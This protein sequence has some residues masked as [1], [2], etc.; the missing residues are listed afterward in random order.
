MEHLDEMTCLLYLEGQFDAQRARACSDHVDACPSCRALLRTLE[1]ESLLFVRAL[2]EEEE[3]VPARLLAL[4]GRG[5]RPLAWAWAASLA[6]AATGSYALYA[7]YVQ[8]AQ[9]KLAQ[10][11][12]GAGS[13]FD[14]LLFEVAFWK[15][16][17]PMLTLLETLAFLA[18]CGVA[19]ALLSP[20]LRRWA[21]FAAVLVLCLAFGGLP[22]PTSAAEVRHAQFEVVPTDQT[23]KND[24]IFFGQSLRI[25]GAVDGDVIAFGNSVDVNGRVTGDL[26]SF[27]QSVH[28]T[29]EIDG[30]IRSFS[31][32]LTLSGRVGKNV[33]AFLEKW[34]LEPEGK[35]GGSLTIFA[36]TLSLDGK[37]GR[38]LLAFAGFTNLDGSIGGGM[39][40]RGGTLAIGPT[41]K[42]DGKAL[43]E[44]QSAKYK[45][46]VS[47]E[48]KLA[49]PL[50]VRIAEPHKEHAAAGAIVWKCI[51]TA[52]VFLFGVVLFFLW[53]K[54]A[55]DAVRSADRYGASFGLGGLV[56]C[57]LPIAAVIACV[58]VVG[59]A[60]G[61]TAL[62]TWLLVLLFAAQ[63]IVGAWLGEKLIGR[64]IGTPALVGRMAL[65]LII[66][67]VL[68]AVPFLGFWVRLA[69]VLWGMGALSLAAYRRFASG[70][71]A[72]QAPL[73][74]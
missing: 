17:Q 41:A 29:G 43:F 64:A 56:L 63:L 58:T 57:G 46:D 31:N 68:A 5:V 66:I 21:P 14:L 55:G 74:A 53:P 2:R 72:Q 34:S 42:I 54:F 37:I 30:N 59:L 50:E 48:A 70:T 49:S 38:D 13:L 28:V 9:E 73:P 40:L 18:V 60:L 25:N 12:F 7:G 16:W 62:L 61:L 11:G 24:L 10:A 8:P 19:L 71:P 23:I 47:P 4:P 22:A 33:I 3:T 52:A 45:P 51:W 6:L 15:G 35:I 44:C 67:R 39:D 20:L 69:V 36:E 32:N 27:A 1:R 65:G 26:I